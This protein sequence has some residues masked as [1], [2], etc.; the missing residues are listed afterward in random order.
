MKDEG[1]AD[2]P[3]VEGEPEGRPE[4]CGRCGGK[5]FMRHGKVETRIRDVRVE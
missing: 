2:F 3:R 1:E 4:R 5:G